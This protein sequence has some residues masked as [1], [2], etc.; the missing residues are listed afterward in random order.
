MIFDD[1]IDQL[2]DIYAIFNRNGGIELRASRKQYNG[3]DLVDIRL[4]L[5]RAASL[6][7]RALRWRWQTVTR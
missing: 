6:R 2:D 3:S 1:D 4:W 5:S 7:T